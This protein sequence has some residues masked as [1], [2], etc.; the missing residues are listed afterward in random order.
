MK[1]TFKF[2]L[3]SLV[4]TLCFV[5]CGIRATHHEVHKLK[6]VPHT[7]DIIDFIER[8]APERIVVGHAETPLDEI[9][10]YHRPEV[11]Q[12][13][14]DDEINSPEIHYYI[15]DGKTFE[16]YVYPNSVETSY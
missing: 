5:F 11:E 1:K 12:A 4:L 2:V 10:Q 15:L 14:A 13:L 16:Y 3:V 8:F 6:S 9:W 7:H